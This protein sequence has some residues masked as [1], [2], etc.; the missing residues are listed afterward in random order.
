MN[1]LAT[2]QNQRFDVLEKVMYDNFEEG[3][4]PV[5]HT[6]LDGIYVREI[7]MPAGSLITSKRHKT[8][9]PFSVIEGVVSVWVNG[10]KEQL[11]KAPY[12][13]ITEPN[14]RR[15]LYIHEDCKWLTYHLNP[16]NVDVSEI[17]C[18]IID[19]HENILLTKNL[20]T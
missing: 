9:H 13:G 19:R 1:E 14:T 10:G 6:F 20:I 17:E 3:D 16:D 15:I 11:I 7:F 5:T 2:I 12:E 18:R 8:R 4:F